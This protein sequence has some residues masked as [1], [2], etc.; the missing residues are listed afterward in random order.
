[1]SIDE[2]KLILDALYQATRWGSDESATQLKA[3]T[4]VLRELKKLEEQRLTMHR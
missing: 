3:R 1:M 4:I 2:L